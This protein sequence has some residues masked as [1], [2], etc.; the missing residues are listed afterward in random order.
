MGL[1]FVDARSERGGERERE[2]T[3]IER[4]RPV[5]DRMIKSRSRI[6]LSS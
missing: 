2:G 1:E 5:D 4:E 3:Q 6:D